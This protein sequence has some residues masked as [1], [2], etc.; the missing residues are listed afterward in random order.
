MKVNNLCEYAKNHKYIVAR[1]TDDV[2]NGSDLWFWGAWDDLRQAQDA[3][4]EVGG[5]VLE[6]E[7]V[8]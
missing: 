3:A 8:E 7:D 1:Q 6:S 4:N 5:I 2:E